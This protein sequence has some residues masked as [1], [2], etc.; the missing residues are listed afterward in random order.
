M[1]CSRFHDRPVLACLSFFL[2]GWPGPTEPMCSKRFERKRT[3][4]APHLAALKG[5]PPVTHSRPT[6]ER[7]SKALA[8]HVALRRP[9][10]ELHRYLPVPVAR[11]QRTP[12]SS[13]V[14]GG[15]DVDDG[16]W[17]QALLNYRVKASLIDSK[18]GHGTHANHISGASG[19]KVLRRTAG[20]PV[21]CAG[22]DSGRSSPRS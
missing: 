22:P 2:P 13:E 6:E 21:C 19:A 16:A 12:A 5:P 17:L 18:P 14:R 15:T 7:Q 4:Q 3:S 20:S 8:L 1:Y 9:T 11:R 10:E